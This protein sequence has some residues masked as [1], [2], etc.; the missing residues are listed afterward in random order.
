M[1]SNS[2]IITLF[3]YNTDSTV[4]PK[5]SVIMRFQYHRQ[6]IK[7][8]EKRIQRF[9]ILH[10][11]LNVERHEACQTSVI[12]SRRLKRIVNQEALRC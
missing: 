4:D 5:I 10:K 8:S 1:Y 3:C 7:I 6:F 11:C 12:I 9:D 2:F